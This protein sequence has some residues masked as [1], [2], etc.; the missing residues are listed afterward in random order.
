MTTLKELFAWV[1]WWFGD[2]R[3]CNHDEGQWHMIECG[4]GKA[5]HCTK[6][7]KCLEII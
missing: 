6:C 5:R 2:A 7:G 1:V 4:A 3:L